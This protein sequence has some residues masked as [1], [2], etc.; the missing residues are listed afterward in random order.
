MSYLDPSLVLV[1]ARVRGEQAA[2]VSPQDHAVST[3]PC[4]RSDN[5]IIKSLCDA[6]AA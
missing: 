6:A 3:W 1:L 2:D 5:N 4:N